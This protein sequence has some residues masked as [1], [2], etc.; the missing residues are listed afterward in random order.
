MFDS[1]ILEQMILDGSAEVAGL[2]SE[3]GEFLYSFTPKVAELYPELYVEMAQF[4]YDS[5]VSL[6]EKGF[7]DI[8]LD[9]DDPYV[10]LNDKSLDQDQI[11]TLSSL[12]QRLLESVVAQIKGQAG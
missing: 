1:E 11:K 3:T 7:L 5:V 12:E 6:W 2:D 8:D 9:S 10:I 4:Y